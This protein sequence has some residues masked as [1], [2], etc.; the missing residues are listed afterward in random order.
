MMIP[1]KSSHGEMGRPCKV[2][3]NS[4]DPHC[5]LLLRNFIVHLIFFGQKFSGK[6]GSRY[7]F[8][9]APWPS[10]HCCQVALLICM[11]STSTTCYG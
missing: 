7:H 11:T 6:I 5:S 9:L 2:L 1:S 8:F 10:T 3:R 4:C